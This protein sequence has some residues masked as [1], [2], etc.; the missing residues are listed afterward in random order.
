VINTTVIFSTA[1]PLTQDE[2]QQLWAEGVSF[3]TLARSTYEWTFGYRNAESFIDAVTSV[4]NDTQQLLL[5][6]DV[7]ILKITAATRDFEE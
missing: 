4:V 7:T 1:K 6:H 2:A 3:K 5:R